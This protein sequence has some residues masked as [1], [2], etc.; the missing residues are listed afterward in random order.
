L[1]G[2]GKTVTTANLGISMAR[3]GNRVLLIDADF[4]NQALTQLLLG[5]SG[6]VAEDHISIPLGLTEVVEENYPLEGALQRIR[7]RPDLEITLLARG[8]V[9]VVA[10]DFFSSLQ[11]R[12][13]VQKAAAEFDFVLVDTP[14]FLQVAYASA[15][16]GYTDG[17]AVVV[18]HESRVRELDELIGR[19]AFLDVPVVGYVYNLAP[20]RREMALVEGSMQDVLGDQGWTG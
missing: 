5:G 20:F 19:L 2:S 10:I 13:V 16:A 11:T 7:L 4:G 12:Q 3:K 17:V 6:I 14:P 9:P 15:V 18:D 1:N 8:R